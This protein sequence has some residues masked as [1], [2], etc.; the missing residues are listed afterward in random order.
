MIE[1][2]AALHSV[3]EPIQC[4]SKFT[5]EMNLFNEI[6]R[7]LNIKVKYRRI[8][9]ESGFI[10]ICPAAKIVNVMRE[11]TFYHNSV[12]EERDNVSNTQLKFPY[13]YIYIYTPGRAV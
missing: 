6:R 3:S 11:F 2:T 4:I 7:K 8:L 10:E 1:N 12:S 9:Q 5:Y 13:I